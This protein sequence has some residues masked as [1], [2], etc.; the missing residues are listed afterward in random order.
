MLT[1]I[2]FFDLFFNFKLKE[3]KFSILYVVLQQA[4][5][6]KESFSLFEKMWGMECTINSFNK[7]NSISIIELSSFPQSEIHKINLELKFDLI[8]LDSL[9]LTSQ[10]SNKLKPIKSQIELIERN[11][12]HNNQ[13]RLRFPNDLDFNALPL[14]IF[15]NDEACFSSM[16]KK[17]SEALETQLLAYQLDRN[18]GTKERFKQ[19]TLQPTNKDVFR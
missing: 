14:V 19:M 9:Y 4:K 17:N 1:D 5:K 3:K 6:F 8:I 15:E 12:N 10:L 2:L 18:H 13:A 16:D 11:Q 7:T